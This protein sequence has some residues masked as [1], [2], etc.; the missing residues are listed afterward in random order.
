MVIIMTAFEG[1]CASLASLIER[2]LSPKRIPTLV[3]YDCEWAAEEG[4]VVSVVGWVVSTFGGCGVCE[5]VIW[6]KCVMKD[7][8]LTAHITQYTFRAQSGD[9]LHRE[10]WDLFEKN[11]ALK[12]PLHW[13]A[14]STSVADCIAGRPSVLW[15]RSIAKVLNHYQRWDPRPSTHYRGRYWSEAWL[16]DVDSSKLTILTAASLSN[17]N[18]NFSTDE[19]ESNESE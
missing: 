6:K 16:G 17:L 2:I 4:L 19:D 11:V 8:R 5:K 9:E 7:R 12:Q 1:R 3:Y 18:T 15:K 14:L 10:L 13:P